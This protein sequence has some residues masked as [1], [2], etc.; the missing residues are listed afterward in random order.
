MLP[1]LVCCYTWLFFD[2]TDELKE[3]RIGSQ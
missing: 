3:F 2:E 1:K